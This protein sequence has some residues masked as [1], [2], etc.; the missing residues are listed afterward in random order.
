VRTEPAATSD[1][2]QPR[3]ALADP[4]PAPAEPVG[5]AHSVSGAALARDGQAAAG[6][7]R[8]VLGATGESGRAVP[9]QA[10]PIAGPTREATEGPPGAVDVPPPGAETGR[11]DA[12]HTDHGGGREPGRREIDGEVVVAGGLGHGESLE[13]RK[14][15]GGSDPSAPS[16]L[17]PSP[18]REPAP[19]HRA[20]PAAPPGAVAHEVERL[21]KLDEMRAAARHDGGELRLEVAPD[22]LG[23]IE[24]RIAVRDDAVH[25]SLYAGHDHARETLAAH[26]SSLEVALERSNLRL[27]G[28]SVGLGERR[29]DDAADLRG[30]GRRADGS[31]GVAPVLASAAPLPARALGAAGLSLRA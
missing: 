22:G 31:L 25:A 8:A 2:P 3:P 23:R 21:L 10:E 19:A 11:D 6:G 24:V 13:P 12:R 27:E 18:A 9:G 7:A 20:A 26:R 30:G 4:K 17:P 28:F 1:D 14:A 15:G 29:G 16:P 5:A